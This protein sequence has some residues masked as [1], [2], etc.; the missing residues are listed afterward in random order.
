MQFA[1]AGSSLPAQIL[2]SDGAARWPIA[3]GQSNGAGDLEGRNGAFGCHLVDM[4]RRY[5]KQRGHLSG[6]ENAGSMF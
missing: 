2:A 5:L 3:W 4:L 6:A 1:S